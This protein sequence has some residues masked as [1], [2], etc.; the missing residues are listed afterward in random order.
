MG[1]T[2]QGGF[3]NQGGYQQPPAS[4]PGGG[5]EDNVAST[6]CYIPFLI[7][8][9][10]SIVFLLIEPYSRRPVV[11]FHAFQSIFLSVALFVLGIT[12]GILS[13]IVGMIPMVGWVGS[14]LTFMLSMVIWLGSLV[15][16]LFLMYKAYNNQ[17]IV[18]PV[19][20]AHAEKQARG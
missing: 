1:S 8:L 12:L 15:L 11:R 3:S 19:V 10:V 9:I 6:V 16:Y 7:G 4:T 13:I 20:G 17:R 2:Q 14:I 18:L 5:L